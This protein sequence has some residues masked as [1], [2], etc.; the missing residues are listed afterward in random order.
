VR[1]D[2]FDAE[3][4]GAVRAVSTRSESKLKAMLSEAC[5]MHH[6]RL[7]AVSVPVAYVNAM[8]GE[9][10]FQWYVYGSSDNVVVCHYPGDQW[11]CC[12]KNCMIS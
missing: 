4:R 9:Q 6:Q 1:E 7:T 10:S 11:E 2:A 8:Y 3:L 5:I 12:R